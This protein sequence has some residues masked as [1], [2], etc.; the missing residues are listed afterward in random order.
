LIH[1]IEHFGEF[2]TP[3]L[4]RHRRGFYFFCEFEGFEVI[5]ACV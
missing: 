1:Y 3:P 4:I 5:P 2:K